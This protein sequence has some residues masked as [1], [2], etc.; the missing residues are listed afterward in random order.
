MNG[1]HTLVQQGKVLYLGISDTP[2]W[3]VSQANQYV[4]DHCKT[5]FVRYQ[6]NWN[7]MERSFE[8][9]IIPMCKAHGMALAPWGVLAGG[10]LHSDEEEEKCSQSGEKGRNVFLTTEWKRN[11]TER[12]VSRALDSVEKEVGAKHVTSVAIAYVMQKAPYIFPII[13][14]RKV[15]YLQANLEALEIVLSPEQIQYLESAVPFDL[16]FPSAVFETETII[17]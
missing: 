13:G 3:A 2:A 4:C 5:A 9:D 7:V 16:G 8:R 12:V 10:K 17:F 1:L 6:G 14:G 15:E 11:E